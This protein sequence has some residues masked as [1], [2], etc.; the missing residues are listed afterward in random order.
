MIAIRCLFAVLLVLGLVSVSRAQTF[1]CGGAGYN[2]STIGDMTITTNGYT[3]TV[4]PCRPITTG[5]CVGKNATFC[6]GG[7][8]LD[9]YNPFINVVTWT[10]ITNGVM[11]RSINGADTCS[12]GTAVRTGAV[13]YL[14]NATATTAFLS[15]VEEVEQCQY[16]AQ[17]QTSLVCAAPIAVSASPVGLPF[18]SNTCGGGLYDLTSIDVRDYVFTAGGSTLYFRPCTP[19]N[20]TG[21]NCP[22]GT[23]F[24]QSGGYSL[25][26]GNGLAQTYTLQPDGLIIQ[27]QDG[28]QCGTGNSN[29]G[30]PREANVYL[31]CNASAIYPQVVAGSFFEGSNNQNEYNSGTEYCHYTVTIQ[32][33]A[34][35]TRLVPTT[36]VPT[37]LA[38]PTFACGGAGVDLSLISAVDMT[39]QRPSPYLDVFW[40]N[41]C[42]PLTQSTCAGQGRIGVS[43]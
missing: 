34:V 31:Q 2:L 5:S 27:S 21:A 1:A 23:S 20:S 33:A 25:S 11:S 42:R 32:T 16:L 19:I 37:P 9:Y 10:T 35:C 6:Q 28:T 40:V 15:N 41:P 24:C 22:A 8:V 29:F 3:W 36:T 12:L 17:V 26:A 18:S 13:E 39:Y 43:G 7:T 38:A 14:C 4:N 30:W